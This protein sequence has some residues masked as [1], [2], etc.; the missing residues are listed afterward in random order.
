MLILHAAENFFNDRHVDCAAWPNLN[1]FK[2]FRIKIPRN[3]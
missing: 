1:S 2:I 3:A